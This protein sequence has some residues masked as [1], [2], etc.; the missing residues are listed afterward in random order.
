MKNLKNGVDPHQDQR[1]QLGYEPYRPSAEIKIEGMHGILPIP[2]Q[3]TA[4]G[5]DLD[6]GEAD[7]EHNLVFA[8][9][10]LAHDT[11]RRVLIEQ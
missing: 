4:E 7:P 10:S 5:V 9:P 6:T 11:Y 2:P 1:D 8:S 3:K